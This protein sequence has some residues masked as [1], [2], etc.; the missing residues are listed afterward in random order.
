MLNLEQAPIENP[1]DMLLVDKMNGVLGPL[2]DDTTLTEIFQSDSWK[3]FR[4]GLGRFQNSYLTRALGLV[5]L[6]CFGVRAMAKTPSGFIDPDSNSINPLTLG[7]IRKI[8][9]EAMLEEVGN[10]RAVKL[11]LHGVKRIE[12]P[13]T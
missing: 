6:R 2:D 13:S 11:V 8:P 10:R 12:D 7:D 5:G 4:K 1:T 9:Y 3:R